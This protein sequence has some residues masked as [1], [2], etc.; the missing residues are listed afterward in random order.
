MVLVATAGASTANSYV[1]VAAATAFLHE[2]LD[3][4]PWYA[5]GSTGDGSLAQRREAG[6][7]WATQLLDDQMQWY[8]TPTSLT[9]ALAWPQTGQ[10]DRQWQALDAA[11]VP[12]VVQRA[13]AFYALELLRGTTASS[14]SGAGDGVKRRKVGDTEIEYFAAPT[15]GTTVA[16]LTS[17]PG[18]V[19]RMLSPYG[20]LR[21]GLTVP[22]VRV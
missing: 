1:T 8:G 11:T 21:G 7:I 3:T 5:E 19:R 16:P 18:E 6:L 22:L 20:R 14:T 10:V 12:R 9:Q 17:M 15:S 13:T 2:R 4:D